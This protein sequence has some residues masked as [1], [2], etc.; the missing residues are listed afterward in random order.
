M[1]VDWS[2]TIGN[3]SNSRLRIVVRSEA[4]SKIKVYESVDNS[5]DFY[6]E[7]EE[8]V[9]FSIYS[10]RRYSESTDLDWIKVINNQGK[11]SQIIL[12]PSSLDSNF[13]HFEINELN[14]FQEIRQYGVG[15]IILFLPIGTDRP[16]WKFVWWFRD[17]DWFK[18]QPPVTSINHTYQSVQEKSCFLI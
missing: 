7:N 11:I 8:K 15:Y 16:D 10:A 18:E 6:L 13:C 12:E 1:P 2:L 3:F 5:N 14:S 17:P 9:S 4:Y